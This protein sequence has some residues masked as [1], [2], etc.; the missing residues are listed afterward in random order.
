VSLSRAPPALP[1]TSSSKSAQPML[2]SESC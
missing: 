2:S 1:R